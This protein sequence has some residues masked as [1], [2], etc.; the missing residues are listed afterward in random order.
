ML[1]RSMVMKSTTITRKSNKRN[2]EKAKSEFNFKQALLDSLYSAKTSKDVMNL[3]SCSLLSTGKLQD[4]MKSLKITEYRTLLESETNIKRIEM[5]CSVITKVL[6]NLNFKGEMEARAKAFLSF[7]RKMQLLTFKGE[8]LDMLNDQIA[9]RVISYN[10]T[11][12]GVRDCFKIAETINSSLIQ[13]GFMPCSIKPKYETFC[14]ESYPDIY[15]PQNE[16]P[17]VLEGYCKDYISHPK[18]NGY[19]SLHVIYQDSITGRRF[20]LQIRTCQMHLHAEQGDGDHR[21]YK[22]TRYESCELPEIDFSK[23]HI[24]GISYQPIGSDDDNPSNQQMTLLDRVGIIQPK[25]IFH[26]SF[27]KNIFGKDYS[28]IMKLIHNF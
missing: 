14:Q 6:E 23:L 19:Q 22:S 20:E 28:Q 5:I 12:E 10:S 21:K 11:P 7:V 2:I 9:V 26:E 1:E 17:S 8:P 27:P 24:D 4:S 13:I 3:Y 25:V 16:L 18:G 15:V